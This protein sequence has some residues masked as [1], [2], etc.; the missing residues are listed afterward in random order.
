MVDARTSV[1]SKNLSDI[2]NRTATPELKSNK[3]VKLFSFEWF[4]LEMLRPNFIPI[5]FCANAE[6]KPG[7][8]KKSKINNL[9]NAV[10]ELFNC[11]RHY[12]NR[13]KSND[14]GK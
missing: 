8:K 6:F 11:W 1:F 14:E 3:L 5:S 2:L 9:F 13:L 12:Q 10:L 4:T 7:M